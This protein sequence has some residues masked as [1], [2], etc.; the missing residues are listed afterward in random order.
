[1]NQSNLSMHYVSTRQQA[2]EMVQTH[3]HFW[4]SNCG[5]RENRGFCSRSRMD[6]CLTFDADAETSGSG[7]K[8]AD[9]ATVNQIFSDAFAAH[10]VTRPFRNPTRTAEDGICFCC[11]DCCEYF[12]NPAETCD[13]GTKI[14]VSSL[15]TCLDCD[16]C[17][18]YCYFGARVR[19]D[20]RLVVDPDKC[21]GCGICADVCTSGC[22]QMVDR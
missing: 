3:D 11:D 21:Y 16:V 1:M 9:L 5:C 8:A 19:V 17:T 14:A 13:K 2:W 22:I 18:E 7:K 6:L 15:D 20:D 10:L 12:T 4:V